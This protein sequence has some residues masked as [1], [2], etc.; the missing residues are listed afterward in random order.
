M[1]DVGDD[2][3]PGL[4]SSNPTALLALLATGTGAIAVAALGLE[5]WT[6]AKLAG[7]ADMGVPFVSAPLG[8]ATFVL[9]ALTARSNAL[10]SVPAFVLGAAYWI[11]FAVAS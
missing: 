2:K 9:A 3:P 5:I 7:L 4:F 1:S 8:V 10:W 11:I 6:G